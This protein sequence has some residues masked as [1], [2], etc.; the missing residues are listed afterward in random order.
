MHTVRNEFVL[1]L[2]TLSK[3]DIKHFEQRQGAY[4]LLDE[5]HLVLLHPVS[6]IS[7]VPNLLVLLDPE[8]ELNDVLPNL[9][10]RVNKHFLRMIAH[11]GLH[12]LVNILKSGYQGSQLY[13]DLVYK[14]SLN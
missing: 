12:F 10:P 4:T 11:N 5:H 6:H 14:L 7:L 13:C 1:Q 3:H 9:V 8:E 2:A